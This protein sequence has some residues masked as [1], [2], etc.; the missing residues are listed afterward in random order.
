MTARHYED[1][2]P[3]DFVVVGSGAAGGVIAR[4]LAI[5]DDAMKLHAAL[6][7]KI[8]FDPL[9]FDLN[10]AILQRGE[11]EALIRPRVFRISN[12]GQRRFH[13]SHHRRQNLISC[14][15]RPGQVLIDVTPNCGQRTREFEQMLKF[16]LI[17]DHPPTRMISILL[18]LASVAAGCLEMAV[19]RWA[20]PDICPGRRDGESLDSRENFG[21]FYIFAVGV[22]ILKMAARF[23]SRDTGLLVAYIAEFDGLRR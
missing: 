15:S 23:E 7:A 3:V 5:A 18:A 17:A 6:R 22:A 1:S 10:V 4:E 16:V 11:A 13:Q 20:N 2:S 8:E 9:P 14:Q 12:S 19:R 21:I